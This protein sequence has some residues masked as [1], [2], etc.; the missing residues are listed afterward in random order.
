LGL[1]I[2]KGIVQKYDGSLTCRTFRTKDGSATCFRVF[3]PV[4]GPT[5]PVGN[6]TP[7]QEP[8]LAPSNLRSSWQAV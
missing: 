7:K 5:T 8:E 3:L 6:E 1:W 4:S 2:S